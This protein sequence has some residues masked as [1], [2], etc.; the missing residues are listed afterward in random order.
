M[1][2]VDLDFWQLQSRRDRALSES[3]KVLLAEM[4]YHLRYGMDRL[5]QK[6]FATVL[7][8]SDRT[9]RAAVRQAVEAG[10][11]VSERVEYGESNRYRA[12]LPGRL[13]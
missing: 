12:I 9:V 1:P 6:H 7:G 10:W 2:K 8:W 13:S 4:A 3:T 11:L 5:P